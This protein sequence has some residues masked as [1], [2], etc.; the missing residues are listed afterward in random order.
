VVDDRAL[1]V[2]PHEDELSV[3]LEK[4]ALVEPLD[5]AVGHALAVTD[6]AT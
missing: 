1:V 4:V 6:H 2:G 5:L 3:E